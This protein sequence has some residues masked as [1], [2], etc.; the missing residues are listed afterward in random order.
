MSREESMNTPGD[1]PIFWETLQRLGSSLGAVPRAAGLTFEPLAVPAK[2]A[3]LAIEPAKS[4]EI[5]RV[6]SR[7]APR[8][9]A[10]K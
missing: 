4:Q 3:P 7:R 8:R 6:P 1:T 5:V 10:G 2:R 9:R